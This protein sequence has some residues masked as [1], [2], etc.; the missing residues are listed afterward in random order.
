MMNELK[1]L[2][3]HK[4]AKA[5]QARDHGL[6]TIAAQKDRQ[7]A[8]ELDA[9]IR[10]HEEPTEAMVNAGAEA[11][12]ADSGLTTKSG[13]EWGEYEQGARACFKAMI[14]AGDQDHD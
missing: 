12:R 9:I 7:F 1:R 10:R 6:A 5:D 14:N 3:D 4:K 11:I 2:R 13:L 8:R